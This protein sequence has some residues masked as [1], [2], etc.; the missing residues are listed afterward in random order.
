M[1]CA[2]ERS[3]ASIPKSTGKRIDG[4]VLTG[5]MT[6]SASGPRFA[7]DASTALRIVRADPQLGARRLLVGPS[8]LRSH[9]MSMLYREVRDGTVGERDARAQLDAI[10]ALRIRLLGDRVSRATAWKLAR[11]LDWDDT[12]LAEYIAVAVLRADVLIAGDRR[13]ATAASGIVA[14]ATYDELC[15]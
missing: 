2:D 11:Q 15:R 4:R 5:A 3:R 1:P 7:I 13:I 12:Q 14:L 8:V 10:A 6:N 9:V